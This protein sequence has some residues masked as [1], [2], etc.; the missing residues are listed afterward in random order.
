MKKIMLSFI[1][2]LIPLSLQ[3]EVRYHVFGPGKVMAYEWMGKTKK[4]PTLILLP[5]VN[6]ALMSSEPAA[7]ELM[8]QGW[9][10]LLPSLPTHPLS[11]AGLAVTEVPYFK[12]DNTSRVQHFA[13]D[14]SDLVVALKIQN[15]IPVSLSYSSG[16]SAHLDPQAFPRVIDTVPLVTANETNPAAEAMTNQ[17]KAAA[18]L[19]PFMGPFWLRATLD[20]AYTAHWSKTVTSNNASNPG[21]YGENPR[22]LD[23]ISGYVA[24]ARAIEDFDFS[25]KDFSA[26]TQTRDFVIAEQE[27]P[28]RLKKQI[29]VIKNYLQSGKPCRVVVIKN[30][31]HIAPAD[32]PELYMRTVDFLAGT[33]MRGSFQFKEVQTPSD[34]KSSAWQGLA[35]FEAWIA[36]K[37]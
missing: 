2:L 30:S 10:I 12:Y 16:I 11:I 20:Q 5:G 33:Q 36:D 4:N 8:K 21:F 7:Q 26:D 18:S 13:Q 17:L 28:L 1:A 25:E 24:I 22:L 9:N 19:N 35:E 14:I 6:R 3:A 23:I 32:Q 27:E 34:F 37:K 31:G 29:V 15:A